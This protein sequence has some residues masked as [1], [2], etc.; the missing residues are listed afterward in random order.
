MSESVERAKTV[1]FRSFPNATLFDEYRLFVEDTARFSDRRQAFSNVM[2]A[3]NALLATGVSVVLKDLNPRA[4]MRLGILVPLLG[5]GLAAA[6]LW[7][8]LF[9]E[10][11][12]MIRARVK[13]LKDMECTV[14]KDER[15]GLYHFLGP[16]FYHKEGRERG[17]TRL[18]RRLPW[19]FMGGV[20]FFR[21]RCGPDGNLLAVFDV[22]EV[23]A[24]GVVAM[25]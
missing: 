21:G 25:P 13:F 16:E 15:D 23:R 7:A 3:V 24:Y 1:K 8:K 6:F 2:V 12:E 17:F 20:L 10:Y 19:I 18:E 4:P 14:G 22:G 9:G 11:E 5:A